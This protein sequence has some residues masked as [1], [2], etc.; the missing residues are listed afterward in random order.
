[1]DGGGGGRDVVGLSNNRLVVDLHVECWDEQN[2][3]VIGR[4][5]GSLMETLVEHWRC[6]GLEVGELAVGGRAVGGR[7]VGG[8]G[9][10]AVLARAEGRVQSEDQACMWHVVCWLWTHVS[11]RH[12]SFMMPLSTLMVTLTSTS[13]EVIALRGSF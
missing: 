1:M 3:C 6:A 8:L 4:V 5:L 2:D 13:I 7:T 11:S 9:G 12:L 10:V